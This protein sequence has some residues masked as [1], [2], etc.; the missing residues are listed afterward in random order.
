MASWVAPA[1][2]AEIWG[3]S[4]DQILAGIA[5]GSI[6]SQVDGQFLFVNVAANGYA[7][8]APSPAPVHH[9]DLSKEELA[10]LT[11]EPIPQTD[12][13]PIPD[14]PQRELTEAEEDDSA[15]DISQWRI[16]RLQTS[17]I[18]RPPLA[19]AA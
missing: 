11:F 5:D 13:P 14:D 9:P 7:R 8:S 17:R 10:A 12:F 18:R 4:V 1:I 16:S 6:A 2:A 19:Q 15:R 3:V